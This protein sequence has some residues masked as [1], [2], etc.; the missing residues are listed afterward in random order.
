MALSDEDIEKHFKTAVET[1]RSDT[2]SKHLRDVLA[3]LPEPSTEGG[4]EGDDEGK[5]PA[6]PKKDK[7]AEPGGESPKRTHFL[8]KNLDDD[9]SGPDRGSGA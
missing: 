8:F 9:Y 1:L 2:H 4:T 5:P 6:P 7:P 3:R